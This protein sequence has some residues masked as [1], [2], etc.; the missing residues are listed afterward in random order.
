MWG[1]ICFFLSTEKTKM[2]G[3]GLWSAI[4]LHPQIV[5]CFMEKSIAHFYSNFNH[6]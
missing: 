1:R 4:P 3:L 6:I 2:A 5:E